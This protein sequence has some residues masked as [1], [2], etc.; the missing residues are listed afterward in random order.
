MI[1][2]SPADALKHAIA[3]SP[4]LYPAAEIV[5]IIGF[6]L[7]V[8]PVIALDLRLLGVTR[9]GHVG[10]LAKA[11]L[12]WSLLGAVIAVCAGVTLFASDA[13]SL[14]GNPAFLTKL[15]LLSAAVINAITFHAIAYRTAKNCGAGEVP[16]GV[17]RAQA[18]ASIML[19]VSVIC[20][21]RLIA[22]V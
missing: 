15:C 22:Y 4:W 13:K 7:V 5:H 16:S 3:G 19:W 20:A 9:A 10:E 12:P 21:G 18:L 1:E 17:A 14:L 6:V 8:G 2:N 11:L